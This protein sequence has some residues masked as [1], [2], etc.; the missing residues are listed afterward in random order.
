[1]PAKFVANGCPNAPVEGHDTLEVAMRCGFC[2]SHFVSRAAL[3]AKSR[4]ASM[5][6]SQ[7]AHRWPSTLAAFQVLER[8]IPTRVVKAMVRMR[9]RARLSTRTPEEKDDLLSR[10][11]NA[12]AEHYATAVKSV[13]G[14][15]NKDKAPPLDPKPSVFLSLP[16]DDEHFAKYMDLYDEGGETSRDIDYILRSAATASHGELGGLLEHDLPDDLVTYRYENFSAPNSYLDRLVSTKPG[17]EFLFE[18]R[19]GYELSTLSTAYTPYLEDFQDGYDKDGRPTEVFT[20]PHD[21]RLPSSLE[22][23]R[24]AVQMGRNMRVR[25]AFENPGSGLLVD[26]LMGNQYQHENEVKLSPHNRYVVKEAKV[27]GTP[28]EDGRVSYDWWIVFGP[29]G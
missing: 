9:D 23:V 14:Y 15:Q 6:P 21:P 20:D 3:G 18:T 22:G 10:V 17:E 5:R 4:P 24:R 2:A 26:D 1:M 16:D 8:H 28:M 7:G 19:D 29:K 25:L 27:L 13:E 12:G 11:P